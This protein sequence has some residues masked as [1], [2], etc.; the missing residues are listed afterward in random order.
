MPLK[1]GSMYPIG[2]YLILLESHHH[3]SIETPKIYQMTLSNF[4]SI[5]KTKLLQINLTAKI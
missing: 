1:E 3:F 2:R 4:Y 5:F